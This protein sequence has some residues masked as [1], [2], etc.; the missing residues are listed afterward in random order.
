MRSI[1]LLVLLSLFF[2]AAPGLALDG[3]WTPQQV[4]ELDPDW[5]K[6]IGLEL[7]PSRLW[8]PSRGTGLLAAAINIPGCSAA[9]VSPAGLI[10]TNHH[11]VFSLVQE[12]STAERDLI[13]NGFLAKTR[14]E[15]L[16]GKTFRAAVPRR[17]TDVTSQIERAV[18]KNADDLTRSKAIE[19]KEKELVD[20]CEKTP[21]ARCRVATFDGGLFYTLIESFEIRDVRLV[22]APPLAVGEFGGEIDN[23]TWPRHTGD[24]AILRAWVAPDGTSSDFAPANVAYA[25]EF[26]FP[27]PG[28][29]LDPGDFV[30]VL[31]YPGT[32]YR[33]LLA[34]EMRERRELWFPRRE[35]LFGEWIGIL[36]RHS[37]A[38]DAARIA[39][40][41]RLKTLHNRYK[42]AQGQVAGLERG[43]ILE[44]QLAADRAVAAWAA[45]QPAYRRSLE[46]REELIA[47]LESRL[48][49]WERDFL[50]ENLSSGP[51]A[52]DL[53]QKIV[54]TARE[55]QKPDR[56]RTED[57]MERNLARRRAA[58][59]R[60][61][62]DYVEA[63]DKELFATF[64]RRALALPPA[65]RIAAVDAAFGAEASEADL[66][67]TIDQLY[68]RT[69]V[70]DRERRLAMFDQRP[71]ELQA[72]KDPL[73]DLAFAIDDA[74]RTRELESKR[75]NGA[76]SRL[77]PAWRGAVIAHA[78]TPVAP[79]A[80]STLRVSFA[81]VQGYQPRDAVVFTPQTTLGGIVEK[82]TGASPF[83]VPGRILERAPTA[84]GSRWADPDLGDVPVAFLADADT[85]G[86][87]SG[88]PV[89][90]GRGE[91]VGVNFDR[92]WENVANDFGF[93]PEI[94]RNISVDI[95]YMLWILDEIEGATGLLE[96]LG[97]IESRSGV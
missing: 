24:F 5:L 21:A 51:V 59:E 38:S 39:L 23:W 71:A 6:S 53:A 16:P 96:E 1:L 54:H 36:E 88:S 48:A 60:A 81:H 90:N 68:A 20:R 73:I 79:D 14:G 3:K 97:A 40:A 25:P 63:A 83:D 8:D 41:S 52:L 43:R 66:G 7:P 70:T 46:A 11:C 57:S 26:Y 49:T 30:M 13:S 35:E 91:L 72:L 45:N 27:I 19:A 77:R 56:E 61:Q 82:H 50:L 2:A 65:Q 12:H 69:S 4:L 80:N 33:A 18:P 28:R 17:F 9:F 84:A 37:G 22:Y 32:T 47:V 55:R 89:V 74:V 64:V 94:A 78:G 87:N 62:K 75:R 29:D 42:N 76:I 67:R 10:V 58:I 15:E 31:G 86:G 44:K 92:V 34:E 85:T 95:R 93:N